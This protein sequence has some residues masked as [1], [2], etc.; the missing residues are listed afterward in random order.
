MRFL[1]GIL[2]LSIGSALAGPVGSDMLSVRDPQTSTGCRGC[3]HNCNTSYPRGK[4]RNDCYTGCPRLFQD[5]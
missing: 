4:P 3:Y 2:M 5:C 1:F